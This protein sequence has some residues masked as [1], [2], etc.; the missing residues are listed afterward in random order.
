MA[1]QRHRN[2]NLANWLVGLGLVGLGASFALPWW[3]APR[4]ARIEGRADTIARLLLEAAL[5]L[6]LSFDGD[7]PA[8]AWQAELLEARTAALVDIAEIPETSFV[9]RPSRA[10]PFAGGLVF[11]G[12]HY[13]YLILP[14]R[15]TITQRRAGMVPPLEVYAYPARG[16]STAQTAFFH[17]EIEESSFT[18]NLQADYKG[19]PVHR[20]PDR[21][22]AIPRETRS[23]GSFD[24]RGRDD[25]R[26]LVP[27][28]IPGA[29][30][31]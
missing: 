4:T 22:A 26:W 19:E 24:Y 12:K 29:R 2:F 6:D 30:Q 28:A 18:R 25:E 14:G 23:G 3:T 8:P 15:A 27:S 9:L 20:R 11:R 31:K 7:S 13:E 5:E 21:G 10:E 1:P 16:L 17:G